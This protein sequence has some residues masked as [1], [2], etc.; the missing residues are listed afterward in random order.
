MGSY[1]L[2]GIEFQFLKMKKVLEKEGS[3]GYTTT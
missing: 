3:D 1:S 2:K